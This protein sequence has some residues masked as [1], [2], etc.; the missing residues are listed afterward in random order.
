MEKN[1]DKSKKFKSS[2]YR[3]LLGESVWNLGLKVNLKFNL[4][5]TLK[6]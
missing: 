3:L 6:H 4:K 1:H 2:K 5:V